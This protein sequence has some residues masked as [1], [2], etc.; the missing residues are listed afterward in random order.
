MTPSQ[1]PL[2]ERLRRAGLRPTPARLRILEVFLAAAPQEAL[3]A[4]EVHRRALRRAGRVSLGTVYRTI[5]Q[6]EARALL[7]AE[8]TSAG[9]AGYRLVPDSGDAPLRLLCPANGRLME[10]HD[11]PLQERLMAVARREG[12][13]LRGLALVIAAI[14]PAQPAGTLKFQAKS[15][16]RARRAGAGSY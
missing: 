4:D 2:L 12:V 15:A 7:L 8:Q 5:Y 1:S 14:G 10:L 6:M 16:S 11:T 9:M 3:R 13:D